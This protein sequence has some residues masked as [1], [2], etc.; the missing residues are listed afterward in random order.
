[1]TNVTIDGKDYE[2]EA[3]TQDARDQLQSINFVDQEI[4]KAQ[5]LV[6]AL[7]TAR[8]AYANALAECLPKD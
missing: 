8:N 5:A 4:V 6:A 2:L 3:L 1:M 7:Q